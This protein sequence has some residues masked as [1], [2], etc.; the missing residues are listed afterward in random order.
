MFEGKRLS[1]VYDYE[2]YLRFK[3][4]DYMTPPE[5]KDRKTHP[6]TKLK[7]PA[8]EGAAWEEADEGRYDS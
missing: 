3:F 6:I 2:E 7:L 5:E 1:G 8:G 4:G